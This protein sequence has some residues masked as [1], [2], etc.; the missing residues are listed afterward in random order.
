MACRGPGISKALEPPSHRGTTPALFCRASNHEASSA[1]HG[2]EAKA[3]ALK[4]ELIA[5]E[6]HVLEP[7]AVEQ[8]VRSE[9][10][11]KNR[12]IDAGIEDDLASLSPSE[13][14]LPSST[15]DRSRANCA[16]RWIVQETPR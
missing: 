15:E 13:R 11:K 10:A 2:Y 1:N 6:P 8:L 14:V 3:V 9:G 16:L 7:L 5:L 12:L 4:L